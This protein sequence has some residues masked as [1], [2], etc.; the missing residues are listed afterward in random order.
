MTPERWQRIEELFQSAR[1][2][3]TAG[4]RAAFLDGACGNDTALRAEVEQLLT[5]EDS[6]GSFINTSAVK[7]AAGMIAADHAVQI[8]GKM[9][10]HYK[11]LSAIGAG[12]MGEVYLATDTRHGRQVALKLLPDHLTKDADRVRR[13]QQEARAVLALNHPN[14]VTVYEIGHEGETQFIASELVKGETLRA[15]MAGTPLKLGEALDIATQVA[16]ALAEAHQE[17]VIHRDIKPENIMLRPDGYVKVLDFG[18]AKLTEA[19]QSLETEAPTLLKVQTRPGMVLGSAHYMS[20][21]QARGLHVDERTDIWS[22]GVV[23]YEMIAGRVPFDGETPSDC[24]AAILDKEPPPLVRFAPGVPEA[25][26]LIISTAL[27]KDRDERY[28]SVKELLGALRRLKQRLDASAEL[29]RSQPPQSRVVSTSS[30]S[31]EADAR[32]SGKASATQPITHSTSSAEY[33]AT[34]IK[35]HTTGAVV[36]LALLLVVLV[37]GTFALYKLL[38]QSKPAVPAPKFTALTTGGRAA[39]QLIDGLVTISPDG[40]YVTYSAFDEHQQSAL[41]VKQVS[42]NNQVQLVPPAPSFYYGTTFSPDNEFVYYVRQVPGSLNPTLYRV[43]VI[44]GTPIKVLDNVWSTVGFAPDGRRFAFVRNELVDREERYEIMLA[45]TDGSG[46]PTVLATVKAPQHFPDETAPSWSPDGRTIALALRTDT[47]LITCTVVGVSVADGKLAPL[48]A[49]TWADMGRVLWLPDGSGLIF[50][51]VPSQNTTATQVWYLSYPEGKARRI[52]NDPNGYGGI[53]LGLTADGST[54][55]TIQNR[56]A[57]AVWV[58]APNEDESRARKITSGGAVDGYDSLS[59]LPD[60]RIVYNARAGDNPDLWVVNADGTN[61]RQLTNDAYWEYAAKASPDGRYIVFESE[62]A[63]NLNLWRIDADG[64]NPKQLTDGKG[65]DD[66]AVFSPDSQWVV[67]MSTRTGKPTAWKVSIQGGAP[68]QLTNEPTH[69]PT[70]SPDGKLI[71]YGHAAQQPGQP[72]R[73]ELVFIPFEGGP[74]VKTMVLPDFGTPGR[75]GS[76]WMPDGRALAFVG[77]RNNVPNVWALPLDGAP[78]RQLT[79]FTSDFIRNYALSPDGRQLAV[80]RGLEINDIV[81]IRDFR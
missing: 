80:S 58:V 72:P 71:A 32:L 79:N 63:G 56:T 19:P 53:S 47:G 6:A 50:T 33:I 21:E 64:N 28:H 18:I 4:E 61:R 5:A 35:Q 69:D 36:M 62:R 70:V 52:T 11:I 59:W 38:T 49:Q 46:A 1:L 8:Q 40:K 17:G 74:P 16:A 26:D 24:I 10:A 60:G 44:G 15:R 22:L 27:T 25:L 41:W 23:L 37:G 75:G 73:P 12:G 45:N 20:P 30:R 78:P 7:V 54:I 3:R 55:A 43:P 48:T 51:A 9:V 31:G 29:E 66:H 68:V 81:L 67:F 42:T 39:D 2:R 14:I 57:G 13:F 76:Q 65:V 34:T 77:V